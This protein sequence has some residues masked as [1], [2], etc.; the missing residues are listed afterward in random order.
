MH[1]L[2][3]RPLRSGYVIDVFDLMA[4]VELSSYHRRW[5]ESREVVLTTSQFQLPSGVSVRPPE[6][7]W[8]FCKGKM[9]QVGHIRANCTP[10]FS[11]SLEVIRAWTHSASAIHY[12]GDMAILHC[13][14]SRLTLS[15]GVSR[16]RVDETRLTMDGKYCRN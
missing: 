15:I 12:L 16:N 2:A 13:G 1:P 5:S 4:R 11:N 6:H 8:W 3:S 7:R 10:Q 14:A 9:T